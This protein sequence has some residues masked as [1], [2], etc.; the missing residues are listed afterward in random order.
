M[1]QPRDDAPLLACVIVDHDNPD[2]VAAQL[3]RLLPEAESLDEPTEFVVVQNGERKLDPARYPKATFV[4]CE[5]R[6]FGAAVNLGVRQTNAAA[7]LALN[8]DLIPKPGFIR[9]AR[10][11]ASAVLAS[12]AAG[13]RIGIAGAALF[14][15]VGKRQGSFGPW[16]TLA[17]LLAGLLRPRPLRRYWPTTTRVR[18]VPWATGA[19]LLI[20]R[21][22]WHDLGGFDERFFMYYE[23][24]DFCRRA[25]QAGWRVG[26]SPFPGATHF[27]PY[28][29][30]PLTVAM[31]RMA[32]RSALVYFSKHR[33]QWEFHALAR[34]ILLE[35]WWR[36]REPG[37]TSIAQLV[38]RVLDDPTEVPAGVP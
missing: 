31:A 18:D 6:G 2:A 33:P 20:R 15:A 12:G 9:E 27:Q 17:H 4:A 10:R 25:W 7:I 3:E 36:R 26:F 13:G 28:H 24:V 21:D 16:P 37:W 35:C 38:R 32:R 14:D 1:S 30:R 22:C 23:D 11:L 8:A 19:S 29:L 5:N 34:I